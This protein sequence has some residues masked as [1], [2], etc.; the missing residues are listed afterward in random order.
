MQTVRRMFARFRF[1]VSP[2]ALLVLWTRVVLACPVLVNTPDARSLKTRLS[3]NRNAVRTDA[4]HAASHAKQAAE[5]PR[6]TRTLS[7]PWLPEP[8]DQKEQASW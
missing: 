8:V 1:H 5:A 3:C 6:L 2:F 7:A 4:P